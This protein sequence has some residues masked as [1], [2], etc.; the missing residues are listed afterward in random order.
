M[1][2]LQTTLFEIQTAYGCT[3]E[4]NCCLLPLTGKVTEKFP[5]PSNDPLVTTVQLDK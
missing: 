1:S 3:T 4:K 2:L 5:L